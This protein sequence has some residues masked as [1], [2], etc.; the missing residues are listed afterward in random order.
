MHDFNFKTG[1][2][3]KVNTIQLSFD[4][5]NLGNLINSNWGVIQLPRTVTPITVEGVDSNGTPWFR[6]DKNLN[7]SYVQ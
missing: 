5:I 1:K 7:N 4:V 6:F 3:E 2:K